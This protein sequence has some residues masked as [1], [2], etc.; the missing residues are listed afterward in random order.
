MSAHNKIPR[1]TII[2]PCIAWLLFAGNGF[3]ESMVLRIL[4]AAGLIGAVLSAVHHADTVAHKVG[5]PFG[6]LV[7]AIAIT[8]IETAL[9]ISLMKSEGHDIDTLAR[10]TVFAAIMIILTGIMG[11]CLLLGTIR[12]KVQTFD[13]QGVNAALSAII[14]VAVITMVLP[15][16]TTSVPGPYYSNRQLG[17]I[18]IITLIIYGA[19]VLV[20][21]VINRDD[22]LDKISDPETVDQK[23]E[24]PSARTTF[25][26]FIFLLVSLVIVVLLAETLAPG[27]E[28]WVTSI[29]APRS[30][31]GVMIS[32]IVLLPEGIS[33][34]R[35][36]KNN[37]LQVSLNLGLG[38]ALASL[39]LTIPVVAF[40]AIYEG[41]KLEWG[42][43]KKSTVLLL[44][45]VF[46]VILS[47]R[48]GRT[49]ILQGIILLLIFAVYLFTTIV[50]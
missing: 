17:F 42:L 30:I 34:V 10:D 29:G 25:I 31:V 32:G 37:R 40:V 24:R 15:N 28:K 20:Q 33:A 5:D 4:M 16:Y 43:D 47:L 11:I 2:V 18:A 8:T 50:P 9:I 1:W 14:A 38:S 41:L 6:T 49:N 7:L 26:S 44:L 36:A 13:P 21:T 27:I 19:F 48:T 35:A 12:Y 39:G 22:F 3:T 45:S 23:Q 46:I